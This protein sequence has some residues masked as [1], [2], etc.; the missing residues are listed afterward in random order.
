MGRWNME[1]KCSSLEPVLPCL[2]APSISVARAAHT[3]TYTTL[4]C[5]GTQVQY[6]VLWYTRAFAAALA[7]A[8]AP[9]TQSRRVH[10]TS[11]Y[12]S[13]LP[14]TF[15]ILLPFWLPDRR[16]AQHCT[17]LFILSL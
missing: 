6:T 8:R 3:H 16:R 4:A 9:L 1:A 12:E 10:P 7:L 13:L 2:C 11:S 5:I 15:C 14:T 17:A